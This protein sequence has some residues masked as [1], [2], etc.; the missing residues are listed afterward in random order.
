MW[1]NPFHAVRAMTVRKTLAGL[2]TG[3]SLIGCVMVFCTDSM[4]YA[5]LS[6]ARSENF[7][8][9]KGTCCT[10]G[11]KTTCDSSPP[12]AC[13]ASGVVCTAGTSAFDSCASPSC[14]DSDNSNDHCDSTE[15]GPYSISST[16]CTV[17]SSAVVAC[18]QNG[19]QCMYVTGSATVDF[20]GCGSAV[21]C[22]VTSG[23]ACQ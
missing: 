16:T 20:T 21:I 2:A 10:P 12:F 7:V 4:A 19:Q 3:L 8:G 5:N 6:S 13:S 14:G 22:A 17:I 1:H 15:Y 11:L 9:V 23:V 18:G